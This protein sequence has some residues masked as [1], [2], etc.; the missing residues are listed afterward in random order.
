MH[1]NRSLDLF[2]NY[3]KLKKEVILLYYLNG[4]LRTKTFIN[5]CIEKELH[6]VEGSVPENVPTGSVAFQSLR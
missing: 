3:A 6:E 5:T 2:L 4:I 1:L